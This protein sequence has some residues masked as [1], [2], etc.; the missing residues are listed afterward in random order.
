[1]ADAVSTG[2]RQ[3]TATHTSNLSIYKGVKGIPFYI[4]R[5]C[6]VGKQV[7]TRNR[8]YFFTSFN[9]LSGRQATENKNGF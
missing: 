4:S 5:L 8:K 9:Y 7:V 2:K 1:M 3:Y 6:P